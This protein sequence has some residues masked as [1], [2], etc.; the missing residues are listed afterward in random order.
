MYCEKYVTEIFQKKHLKVIFKKDKMIFSENNEV[1]EDIC[2]VH[3]ET[4]PLVTSLDSLFDL[5]SPNCLW[6]FLPVALHCSSC[7]S[8]VL[9]Y[10]IYNT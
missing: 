9:Q 1:Q 8:T 2:W 4:T 6:Q 7:T 3:S 5:Y 10:T